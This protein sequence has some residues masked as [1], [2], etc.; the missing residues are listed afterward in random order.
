METPSIYW[1]L[2]GCESSR[3]SADDRA[4][5]TGNAVIRLFAAS[6]TACAVLVR[7][8]AARVVAGRRRRWDAA[9]AVRA[10]AA[11]AVDAS[12]TGVSIL[13][14]GIERGERAMVA[15]PE[16]LPRQVEGG[17]ARVAGVLP[18]CGHVD[19]G[20]PELTLQA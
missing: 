19:R 18:L 7:L 14:T 10:E 6:R 13:A 20:S 9:L 3:P 5:V 11:A 1:L 2:V 17:M 15:G 16:F 8:R 12:R 4:A